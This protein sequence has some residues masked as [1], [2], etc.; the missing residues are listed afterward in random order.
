MCA[1]NDVVITVGC[2][3]FRPCDVVPDVVLSMS[4]GELPYFSCKLSADEYK[5][6]E[7]GKNHTCFPARGVAAMYS[8]SIILCVSSDLP[9]TLGKISSVMTS[10]SFAVGNK[11]KKAP[12]SSMELEDLVSDFYMERTFQD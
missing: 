4:S 1:C 11:S 8:S 7:T 3:G 6:A 2:N 5:D 9:S 10:L 12:A